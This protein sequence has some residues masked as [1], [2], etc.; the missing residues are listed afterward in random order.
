MDLGLSKPLCLCNQRLILK[1]D[2]G[3]GIFCNSCSVSLSKL[4]FLKR[5][6]LHLKFVSLKL[7][8]IAKK[9]PLRQSLTMYEHGLK[10]SAKCW[11]PRCVLCT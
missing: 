6:P 8:F 10:L 2:L 1:E 4:N 7:L 3:V 11:D 9:R 5:C